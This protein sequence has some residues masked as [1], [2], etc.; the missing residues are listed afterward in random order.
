MTIIND[1][2]LLKSPHAEK[3]FHDFAKSEPIIDYHCHLPPDQLA[4][5]KRF[6]NITQLWLYGDHYKWRAM[7]TNGIDEHFITGEAS[8]KEK[9]LKWAETV[10]QT[11]RNP[12]FHWTHL[13]LSRYFGVNKY[14][15]PTSAEAIYEECNA[16]IQ[17]EKFSARNI[18]LNMNVKVICTTDDPIDS[19][20]HHRLLQAEAYPVSVFPTFRP[21]NLLKIDQPD[22]FRG[23]LQKLAAVSNKVISSIEDFLEAIE[24]RIDF[25]HEVG[26]RLS[27]HGLNY[28]F[29][30]DFTLSGVRESFLKVTNG[31]TITSEEA[32]AFKSFLLYEVGKMYHAK[33]WTQQFHLGALRDNNARFLRTLGADCGV[34]SIADFEQAERMSRYFNR[35]DNEDALAKTIIY[36][37]NPSQNEVFATMIGNFQ[38]GKIAGKMQFG[39][40]WWFLD[41]KDGMEKQ[42]NAL[43]NMG[44]L[45]RFVGMLTDSR[46]FLSYPRH[47]Y[48][49][50]TLCNL[51][52]EDIKNGE[53]PHDYEW[54]GGIVKNIC[55]GNAKQYFGFKESLKEK[56]DQQVAIS[57]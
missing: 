1:N 7:R 8:D 57:Y 12:L 39:S 23:Y 37:L 35:L 43:S 40:G 10:P 9:F 4:E 18:P 36:N 16:L 49:R 22:F 11:V 6:E 56:A 50:R 28:I 21:D 33:G 55:Y 30:S 26:C 44:L 54:I 24:Q 29:A 5:D 25:F 2:F 20:E 45:S 15:N 53:L 17:T 38:D 3:L 42:L 48:F 32:E 31:G 52:G 51:L 34:D 27:D 41:Q 13:E 46:S 47:E 19:L 14:L